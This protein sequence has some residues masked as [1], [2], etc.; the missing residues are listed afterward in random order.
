M[1]CPAFIKKPFPLPFSLSL[2]LYVS[3][4]SKRKKEADEKKGERLSRHGEKER[5]ETLFSAPFFCSRTR[6]HEKQERLFLPLLQWFHSGAALSS[7]VVTVCKAVKKYLP[8][9]S[10]GRGRGRGCKKRGCRGLFPPPPLSPLRTPSI[11]FEYTSPYL[12]FL[13]PPPARQ[14][15]AGEGGGG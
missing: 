14:I 6:F 10:K 3:F 9:P 5:K 8:P 4:P 15:D 1:S 2:L 13:A 12:D 11:L 7:A